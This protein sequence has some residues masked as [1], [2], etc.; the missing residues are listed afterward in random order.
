MPTRSRSE[1][2]RGKSGAPSRPPAA[3]AAPRR[4]PPVLARIPAWAWPLV[5]PLAMLV[6]L[7]ACRGAP[8]GTA[9][10]DDYSFLHWLRFRHP[11]D[12]F[13]SMG[14]SFYWRP[15]S[16]QIYFLAVGP[17]L[18]QAPWGAALLHG[19]LLAAL[20]VLLYR[21]ARRGFD[22]LLAALIA[23]VPLASESSRVLLGWPSAA[24]HL[25]AL[26]AIAAALHEAL[27]G[28]K[29]TAVL[30][31]AAA[32]LCH[33]AAAPVLVAL[34]VAAWLRTRR[35]NEALV[36]AGLSLAVVVVWEAGYA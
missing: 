20:F 28:R 23:S 31:A 34:P 10:V 7:F 4:G 2:R 11:L 12:F 25:L 32:M 13:D 24:Q 8:L 9:A 3:P 5:G 35:R 15:L 21:C 27:V 30:A 26:V 18:L 19:A 14:A 36:W 22:P 16:R 6:L 1:R 17:W 29:V 33:D